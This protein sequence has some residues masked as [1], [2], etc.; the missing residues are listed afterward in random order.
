MK[1]F[2]HDIARSTILQNVRSMLDVNQA[3]T[4]FK[5]EFLNICNNHAPIRRLQLK[6]RFNPW[7]TDEI[8]HAIYLRNHLHKVVI[9]TKSDDDWRYYRD[10]R[11]KVTSLI[12]KTKKHYYSDHLSDTNTSYK[13]TWLILKNLLPQRNNNSVQSIKDPQIFNDFLQ[14]QEK[15]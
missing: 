9:R 1:A 11:N 7:F 3:W 8:L 5:V 6:D 15:N 14:L 4:F 2:I 10:A 13:D 12:T